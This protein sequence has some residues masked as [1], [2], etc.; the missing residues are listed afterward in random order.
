MKKIVAMFVFFSFVIG[1]FSVSVAHSAPPNPPCDL[2]CIVLPDRYTNGE[3]WYEP[4]FVNSDQVGPVQDYTLLVA[5]NPD[6][7]E[8]VQVNSPFGATAYPGSFEYYVLEDG[9]ICGQ[10]KSATEY[11]EFISHAN[12]LT[13]RRT[14]VVTGKSSE[15]ECGEIFLCTLV[16]KK[17]CP[18]A[19]SK[20]LVNFVGKGL[21]DLSDEAPLKHLCPFTV[22]FPR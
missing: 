17:K 7:I 1:I 14:V 20:V 15:P 11:V 8:L 22:E 4:I 19:K 2:G 13:G 12:S 6:E 18:G 9:H 10:S 3:I 5:Y 16:F 21:S